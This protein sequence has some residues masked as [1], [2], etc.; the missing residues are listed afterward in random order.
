[1]AGC[2]LFV[3]IMDFLGVM[4]RAVRNALRHTGLRN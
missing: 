1:M 2:P 3:K 4:N